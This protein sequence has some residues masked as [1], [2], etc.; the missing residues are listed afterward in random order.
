[1]HKMMSIF[2]SC[3]LLSAISSCKESKPEKNAIDST[4]K[5]AVAEK[6]VS[7]LVIYE[8][9]KAAVFDF[10]LENELKNQ[11]DIA[12]LKMLV[13]AACRVTPEQKEDDTILLLELSNVHL[14]GTGAETQGQED[15]LLVLEAELQRAVSATYRAGVLKKLSF[16][17]NSSSFAVG[18]WRA[19]L[20]SLQIATAADGKIPFEIEEQDANGTYVARYE[21]AN[22]AGQ[23]LK[24]KLRYTKGMYAQQG[25]QQHP[26]Q[27]LAST[28]GPKP[29]VIRSAG[30][31]D[32]QQNTIVQLVQEDTVEVALMEAGKLVNSSTLSLKRSSKPFVSSP[33][34]QLVF[35]METIPSDKPWQ[36]EFPIDAMDASRMGDLT[37][38][39]LLAALVAKA[40][41]AN[42]KLVGKKNDEAVDEKD[43]AGAQKWMA[44]W[45][46][47]FSALPA[48]FRQQPETIKRAE[49]EI[50]KGSPATTSLLGGLS[51][52][53]TPES[54]R[55][56]LQLASDTS[57]SDD[58]RGAAARNLVQCRL[59]TEDTAKAVRDLHDNPLLSR[60][61]IMGIGIIARK[62]QEDGKPDAAEENV[63]WLLEL[64]KGTKEGAV[65]RDILRGIANSAH[66]MVF[67][68][69]KRLIREGGVNDR[70]GAIEA[71]RLLKFGEVNNIVATHLDFHQESSSFVREA[72]V[73]AAAV[74]EPIDPIRGALIDAATNDPHKQVKRKML[75]VL[76]EWSKKDESL[77]PIIE[78]VVA[79]ITL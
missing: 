71:I 21:K 54:Q 1:M 69:M 27:S 34:A 3:M 45:S 42:R 73:A 75:Q 64:L 17:K 16:P 11:A 48:F 66:P 5:T 7:P 51:S 23:F 63:A 67:E 44:D 9:Q 18:I 61:Y 36:P 65:R 52:A 8:W 35:E 39:D 58:V 47:Y 78:K 57:L 38:D 56:L 29:D 26:T 19:L 33:I 55:L 68:E 28:D 22:T 70:A 77:I 50:R 43:V 15:K 25:A 30:L 31:I 20:S 41:D 24:K 12:M 72:A 53:G 79:D 46:R 13:T 32:V 40:G 74:R 10:S 60:F 49:K 37:F 6:S 14:E 2:L 76:K 59:P 62:L 4:S